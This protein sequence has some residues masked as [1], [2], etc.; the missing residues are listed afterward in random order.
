MLSERSIPS[1][2]PDVSDPTSSEH[3]FKLRGKTLAFPQHLRD[4]TFAKHGANLH[5]RASRDGDS[6]TGILRHRD[7]G[8]EEFAVH[9]H[10][11]MGK[12]ARIQTIRQ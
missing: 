1:K 12:H 5:H 6:C 8:L 7:D 11:V 4:P 10:G 3:I 2:T 9:A